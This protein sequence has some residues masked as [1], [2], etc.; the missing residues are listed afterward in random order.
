[1]ALI[2]TPGAGRHK[3]GGGRKVGDLKVHALGY[4]CPAAGKLDERFFHGLD[5]LPHGEGL[6]YLRRRKEK[7]NLL[8]HLPFPKG[9]RVPKGHPDLG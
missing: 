1:M 4:H 6:S 8:G 3:Q 5:G 9:N 2:C 7:D